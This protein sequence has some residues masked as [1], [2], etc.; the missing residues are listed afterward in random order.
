VT[1]EEGTRWPFAVGD[2]RLHFNRSF[3]LNTGA[4]V[5]GVETRERLCN[6]G[7]VL[8][9][10]QGDRVSRQQAMKECAPDFLV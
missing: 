6:A 3:G 10:L 2:E 5:C 1:S 9:K 4:A 7:W 8:A